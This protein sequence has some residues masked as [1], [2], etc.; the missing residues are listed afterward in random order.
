MSCWR[1]VRLYISLC[2]S[3]VFTWSNTNLPPHRCWCEWCVEVVELY[4]VISHILPALRCFLYWPVCVL[5]STLQHVLH[6]VLFLLPFLPP[7]FSFFIREILTFTQLK[8]TLC[9][10]GSDQPS[11]SQLSQLVSAAKPCVTGSTSVAAAPSVD[12]ADVYTC[13]WL[14]SNLYS[15]FMLPFCL[16]CW[17]ATLPVCCVFTC[18]ICD[19]R[20][21]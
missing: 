2:T 18:R 5:F 20:K 8:T 13:V 4:F 9:N 1:Q 15:P 17:G 16:C 21:Y 19:R 3:S 14:S 10:R 11:T 6:S 7:F 12:Y